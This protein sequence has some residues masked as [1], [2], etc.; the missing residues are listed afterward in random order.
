MSC[1]YG[2]LRGP[3]GDLSTAPTSG[4]AGLLGDEITFLAALRCLSA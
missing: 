3:V 2:M 1:L 4:E